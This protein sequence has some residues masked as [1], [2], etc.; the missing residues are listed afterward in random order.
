[1]LP[2]ISVA[3]PATVE[4]TAM[5]RPTM[6]AVSTTQSTVTAP[7]SSRLNF[8]RNLVIFF[9]GQEI[10]V[11]DD[12]L[13]REL[14]ADGVAQRG[15]AAADGRHHGDAEAHDGGGQHDP[16]DGDSA[17]FVTAKLVDELQHVVPSSGALIEYGHR[18]G[19]KRAGLSISPPPV[20][21]SGYRRSNGAP[22]GPTSIILAG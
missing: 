19:L 15:G 13:R 1:M 4:I 9:S 5:P 11:G 18:S 14:V 2:P 10:S 7:S 6:A 22:L 8:A 3:P 21:M 20:R 16:V 17:V 12:G